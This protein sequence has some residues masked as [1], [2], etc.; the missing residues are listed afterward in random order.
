M[1][2]TILV[3]LDGSPIAERALPYGHALAEQTH[4]L[5]L[6]VRAVPSSRLPVTERASERGKAMSDAVAYLEGLYPGPGPVKVETEA[7]FDEPSTTIVEETRQREIDLV[8]MANR[9]RSPLGRF[10]AH[11][12]SEQVI[13]QSETPV[14]LIADACTHEWTADG[15]HRVLVPLDGSEVAERVLPTATALAAALRA[16]IVLLQAVAPPV[17]L[18]ERVR[19]FEDEV[20]VLV[21][22][23]DPQSAADYL[24]QI[25]DRL[26]AQG[27][28]A[29]TRVE[30]GTDLVRTILS[31]T[32]SP[33]IDAV[34]LSTHGAGGIGRPSMGRLAAEVIEH[35][36]V[37]ILVSGP[38]AIR[39]VTEPAEAVASAR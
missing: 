3:P 20:P 24:D 39:H 9:R 28:P 15:P 26:I 18:Y 32:E 22:G 10:V 29:T 21:E 36:R 1:Y 30:V 23:G 5:L 7:Y 19:D 35:C 34:V 17:Y 2:R 37:P 6:L 14:L 16:E 11:S 38:H 4:A 13:R 8:V 31:A 33:G 25:A 27:Q 12:V